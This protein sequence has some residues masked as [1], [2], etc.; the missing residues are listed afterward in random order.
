MTLPES[1]RF[2][3]GVGV[4]GLLEADKYL[5]MV[6]VLHVREKGRDGWILRCVP[7]LVVHND[8]ATQGY[9]RRIRWRRDGIGRRGFLYR[10]IKQTRTE[11]TRYCSDRVKR[12]TELVLSY[13][14]PFVAVS[15]CLSH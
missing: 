11:K 6:P 10:S 7:Y 2:P 13:P 8:T 9:C 15:Y 3:A 12:Q 5:A 14:R 4:I 1:N